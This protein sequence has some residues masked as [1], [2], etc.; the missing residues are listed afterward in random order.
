MSDALDE[1]IEKAERELAELRKAAADRLEAATKDRREELE[2]EIERARSHAA[3]A[4]TRADEI[5]AD[6]TRLKTKISDLEAEL[7][8]LG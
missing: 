6:L 2:R 5:E 1:A 7:K 3:R 4:G 8:W